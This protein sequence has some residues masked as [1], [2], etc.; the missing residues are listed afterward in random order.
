MLRTTRLL[1][2]ENLGMHRRIHLRRTGTFEVRIFVYLPPH[3][4]PRRR[5]EGMSLCRRLSSVTPSY[6]YSTALLAAHRTHNL[7]QRR[8]TLSPPWLLPL[9]PIMMDCLAA[10][11]TVRTSRP[12]LCAR[13]LFPGIHGPAP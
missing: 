3:D 9:A 5:I 7:L 11:T 1:N 13:P 2:P 6:Q 12:A 4:Y 8:L 10:A